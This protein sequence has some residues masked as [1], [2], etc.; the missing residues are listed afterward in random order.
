MPLGLPSELAFPNL[1]SLTTWYSDLNRRDDEEI[2]H[3]FDIIRKLNPGTS[4]NMIC[5]ALLPTPP[6]G[7]QSN[8]NNSDSSKGEPV[9]NHHGIAIGMGLDRDKCN[10]ST[11]LT[12]A[13]IFF[14]DGITTSDMHHIPPP[15]FPSLAVLKMIKERWLV[16][17]SRFARGLLSVKVV[18]RLMSDG[19]EF[20]STRLCCV[21]STHIPSARRV[22]W[23]DMGAQCSLEPNG[24]DHTVLPHMERENRYVIQ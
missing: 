14:W 7:S 11:P 12:V 2:P 8:P 20:R 22:A 19:E 18:L 21:I 10:S 9:L 23:L 6:L 3:I 17:S 13:C 24:R 5:G 1:R 16:S 15:S 4:V